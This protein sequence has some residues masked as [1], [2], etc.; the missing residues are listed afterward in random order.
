VV[1]VFIIVKTKYVNSS[2]MNDICDKLN[3]IINFT[4]FITTNRH[5][6]IFNTRG[7][8][9]EFP[10]KYLNNLNMLITRPYGKSMMYE[11]FVSVK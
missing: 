2:N 6:T 5:L 4:R 7:R 1:N 11:N 3:F 9:L 8:T 10:A